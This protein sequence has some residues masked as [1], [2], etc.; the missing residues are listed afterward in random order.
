[1]LFNIL[2]PEIAQGIIEAIQTDFIAVKS[3]PGAID[4]DHRCS[5]VSFG[6]TAIPFHVNDFTPNLVIDLFPFIQNFFN[7]ILLCCRHIVIFCVIPSH[8]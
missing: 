2:G 5:G 4:C 8:D 7:V 1:M 3:V 6:H